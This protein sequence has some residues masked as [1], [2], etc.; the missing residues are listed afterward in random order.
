MIHTIVTGISCTLD[1]TVCHRRKSGG[2]PRSI[3]IF[4]VNSTLTNFGILSRLQ[5]RGKAVGLLA[6]IAHANRAHST[7]SGGSLR[8]SDLIVGLSQESQ[9]ILRY[10]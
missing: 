9:D 5:F 3:Y 10:G 6:G 1:L 4:S 7:Q 8:Q 2:P